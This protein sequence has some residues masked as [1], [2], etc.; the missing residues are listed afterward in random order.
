M[1]LHGMNPRYTLGAMRN[2]EMAPELFPDWQLWVY[3]DSSVSKVKVL[4][5]DARVQ[6]L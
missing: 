5:S 3:T 1:S 4:P 6:L 2:C